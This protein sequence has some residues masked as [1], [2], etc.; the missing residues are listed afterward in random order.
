MLYRKLCKVLFQSNF[1]NALI[2]TYTVRE[3]RVSSRGE[4]SRLSLI[5]TFY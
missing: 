3:I 4:I 1:V 2:I 5:T